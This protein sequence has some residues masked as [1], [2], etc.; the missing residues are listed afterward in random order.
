MSSHILS[1]ID[2]KRFPAPKTPGRWERKDE[3]GA[4]S[5]IARSMRTDGN[6]EDARAELSIPDV[7]AIVRL[8]EDALRA[9]DRAEHFMHEIAVREW[10]GL[11]ALLATASVKNVR[12]DC[13]ELP[14]P[15]SSTRS[16]SGEWLP[17]GL[18]DASG[19][20]QILQPG[21]SSRRHESASFITAAAELLPSD[22][23]SLFEGCGWQRLGRVWIDGRIVA[24]LVPSVIVAPA[25]GYEKVTRG[26]D[27][28]DKTGW[29]QDPV[30][31]GHVSN[32]D[33]LV[34]WKYVRNLFDVIRDPPPSAVPIAKNRGRILEELERYFLDIE[35]KI[36]PKLI[37]QVKFR[38]P[39]AVA[40]FEGPGY[41]FDQALKCQF[42]VETGPRY[43]SK[44]RLR[45]AFGDTFNGAIVYGEEIQ[46]QLGRPAR[47][48]TLW[49]STSFE[50]VALNPDRLADIRQD[51]AADGFL[52]VSTDDFFT[53]DL[54]LLSGDKEVESHNASMRRFVLPIAPLLL[55]FMS[56][57]DINRRLTVREDGKGYIVSLPISVFDHDDQEQ[58]LVV[59]KRYDRFIRVQP[60]GNLSIWPN[61]VCKDW[62]TYFAY[63]SLNPELAV[64][65]VAAFRQETI[66]AAL[67]ALRPTERA[68][69][70]GKLVEHLKEQSAVRPI[71]DFNDSYSAVFRLAEFPECVLC[72]AMIAPADDPQRPQLKTVGAILFPTAVDRPQRTSKRM[73][74]AID[75]GTTNSC[76]Y[77]SVDGEIP[78]PI[79]FEQR[80]VCPLG[81]PSPVDQ[82]Q[83]ATEFLPLKDVAMPF[84]TLL[85]ERDAGSPD[86]APLWTDRIQYVF[87]TASASGRVVEQ[88]TTRK[89][90]MGGENTNRVAHNLKWGQDSENRLRVKLFLSQ[91]VLQVLAEA[92]WQGVPVG[93][94]TWHFSYPQEAFSADH[95]EQY[96]R[97][98][99]SA[100]E[101]AAGAENGD[102]FHIADDKIFF[103][104]ESRC[105]ARYFAHKEVAYFVGSVLTVDIGGGSTDILLAQNHRGIWRGS[106]NFA[107]RNILVDYLIENPT[108]LKRI[109]KNDPRVTAC[110]NKAESIDKTTQR[111][112]YYQALEILVN[113]EEFS[114]G[115]RRALSTGLSDE[116][117]GLP[118]LSRI[119]T[120]SLAA[121]LYYVGRSMRYLANAQDDSSPSS[122][123]V[124]GKPAF[125]NG[126]GE[127]IAICF[128]GRGSMIF[129]DLVGREALGK[130]LRMFQEVADLPV[131]P[132]ASKFSDDPKHEVA[133]GLLVDRDH[134]RTQLH[135]ERV[136]FEAIL[137]EEM[138]AG[139]RKL[140]PNVPAPKDILAKDVT[141]KVRDLPELEMMKTMFE[142]IFGRTVA[143]PTA[144]KRE[145]CVKISADLDATRQQMLQSPHHLSRRDSDENPHLH[146]EPVYILALRH[147]VRYLVA[148]EGAIT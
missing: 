25:R 88:A 136:R 119:A 78:R 127:P 40:A 123:S 122:G 94:I 90:Q 117:M 116:E 30:S 32:E 41:P 96:E 12:V 124:D 23:R 144:D 80:L 135:L 148:Q 101:L 82:E 71:Q 56:P 22:R 38:D 35:R 140:L 113:S 108:F 131:P 21:A 137:G 103:E 98:C 52:V 34:S 66:G 16:G 77:V 64:K 130:A 5:E 128:S 3:P 26:L 55:L 121:I 37:A 129:R 138:Y 126:N 69:F 45:E 36:G 13:L 53:D 48:T 2:D 14:D 49:R 74:V 118:A 87:N 146:I 6:P 147:L 63:C 47:A 114:A 28:A 70:A 57:E 104:P 27:W 51:A 76:A 145:L 79:V 44:L 20:P 17:P 91:V 18:G 89:A 95:S 125:E 92:T 24:F 39:P 59:E 132:M 11:L 93:E 50:H 65:P 75:F 68:E 72:E 46:R 111:G 81:T 110:L 97:L 100:I 19:Y 105:N 139:E 133:Y 102:L 62:N 141:W 112:Y 142:R 58:R 42:A 85:E 15:I 84:L 31:V 120:F 33:L 83:H 115:L 107:G 54:C 134:P 67:R 1:A 73:R 9:K 43:S 29:L 7:W 99:K 61:F 4:I 60:P 106:L 86:R 10:R 143:L 8:F 109:F